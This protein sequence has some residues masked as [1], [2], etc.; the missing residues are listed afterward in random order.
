MSIG[1]DEKASLQAA[2]TLIAERRFTAARDAL[3]DMRSALTPGSVAA[4]GPMTLLGMPRKLHSAFLKLAK[5]E[6]DAIARIGLQ[7]NL[8]PDPKR[9]T[10]HFCI[11]DAAFRTMTAMNAEPVPRRI[12]QIW[13]GSKPV[14]V[15]VEAWRRHAEATGYD[16]RLWREDDIR[17]I[18]V[19]DNAVFR[20]FLDDGDFPGAVDVARYL[21]LAR[22]GGIYL[23]CDWYPAR[24]DAGFDAFM[25]LVGLSALAEQTPRNLGGDSLLLTNSFIA[26]PPDHPLF[27]ILVDALPGVMA[28]LPGAPAWWATGPVIFTLL[29]RMVAV[30]VPDTGFVAANLPQQAPMDAVLK[31]A[32]KSGPSGF[33]IGWKSW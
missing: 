1:Q 21:I 11:Q 23:D 13:I 9:V 24:D 6:G 5:A 22:E 18:G 16:Y 10:Q 28:E 12:H 2:K 14:P 31:A 17:A 26:A 7:Y 20:A 3:N 32:D 4:L 33:L 27:G 19:Y 8:V 25:P 15:S 29:A 30:T